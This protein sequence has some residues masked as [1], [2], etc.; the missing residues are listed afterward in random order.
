VKGGHDD[1][2][3]YPTKVKL[4]MRMNC[5]LKELYVLGLAF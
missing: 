2:S 1:T 5:V 4:L 3:K